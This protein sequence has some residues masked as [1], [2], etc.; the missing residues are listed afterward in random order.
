MFRRWWPL[1]T[2]S[3]PTSKADDNNHNADSGRADRGS[4]DEMIHD[5][6]SQDRREEEVERGNRGSPKNSTKKQVYTAAD[7]PD[8]AVELDFD[9]DTDMF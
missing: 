3:A 1:S 7:I 8:F 2:S 9:D 5:N 4:S 6:K